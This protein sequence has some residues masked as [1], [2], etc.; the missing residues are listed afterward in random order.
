LRRGTQGRP[1]NLETVPPHLPRL[2]I[3]TKSKKKRPLSS[4]VLL[5]Y[6][7]FSPPIDP[8]SDNGNATTIPEIAKKLTRKNFSRRI[9]KSH[10][11]SI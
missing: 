9:Q 4:I 3:K 7:S 2:K 10:L 8:N 1:E 11:Y 6:L 5:P